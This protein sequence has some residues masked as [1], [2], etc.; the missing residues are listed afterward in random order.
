M[1]E[2]KSAYDQERANEEK[3]VFLHHEIFWLM[4]HESVKN[5]QPILLF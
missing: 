3:K 5:S 4:D 1:R 2:H